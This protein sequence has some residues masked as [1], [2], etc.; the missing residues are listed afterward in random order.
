MS[1]RQGDVAP[2][3]QVATGS[4]LWRSQGRLHLTVIVK[5]TYGL[6][7]GGTMRRA[8]PSPLNED[9]VHYDRR[10][11]QSVRLPSDDVPYLP[12]TDVLFSG[13]VFSPAKLPIPFTKVRLAVQGDGS[14]VEKT[15]HVHGDRQHGPA[16]P[17]EPEPFTE[18]PLVYERAARDPE[19]SENPVGVD[20]SRSGSLPNIVH[21]SDPDRVAGLGPISRYWRARRDRISQRSRE[22]LG[23][24]VMEIASDFDWSYFQAAP[25][26]QQCPH[27]AGDEWVVVEGLDPKICA[28]PS[29]LPGG[30]AVASVWPANR[31]SSLSYPVQMAADA[32]FIDG[33]ARTC[34]VTWRGSF[35][36]ARQAVLEAIYIAAGVHYA[37]EPIDWPAAKAAVARSRPRPNCTAIVAVDLLGT[38][39]AVEHE[40]RA[41]EPAPDGPDSTS[42]LLSS[43]D[44]I[45]VVEPSPSTA[46]SLDP[47]DLQEVIESPGTDQQRAE[48]ADADDLLSTV[49]CDP[50]ASSWP[51]APAGAAESEADDPLNKTTVA[52][53]DADDLL[54]HTVAIDP[55]DD[56]PCDPVAA[57]AEPVA[58]PVGLGA[59]IGIAE[60]APIPALGG[61]LDL[62]GG[63]PASVGAPFSLA[64]APGDP[65]VLRPAVIPGAP[66]CDE[67]AQPVQPPSGDP[68]AETY[69][70]DPAL[71]AAAKATPAGAGTSAWPAAGAAADQGIQPASALRS[72]LLERLTLGQSVA[73]LD[74]S[75]ADLSGLDLAACGLAGAS[76]SGANLRGA[77][78]VK[79]DLSGADLSAADLTHACLDGAK[80]DDANLHGCVLRKASLKGVTLHRADLAEVDGSAANLEKAA[81][82]EVNFAQGNWMG[83]RFFDAQID[84]ADFSKSV[85]DRAVFDSAALRQARLDDVR[86]M[87]LTAIG[88]NLFEV[89]ARRAVL[90][91]CDFTKVVAEGSRWQDALLDD[92]SFN[93]A[94]LQRATFAEASCR[95]IDMSGAGLR[96]IVFVGARLD[97]A[98][99][100]HA[101][102]SRSSLVGLDLSTVDLTG[103]DQDD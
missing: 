87:D 79:A 60:P 24:P 82:Y 99:F 100:R 5:A 19:G 89:N 65:V 48:A 70:L 77:Y 74:L 38:L 41:I 37:N 47:A 11:T 34:T 54:G 6:K 63:P 95:R 75:G 40:E 83:T 102:L 4:L 7:P 103:A 81:G 71:A 51:P 43:D 9:D 59:T 78:L 94:A 72:Q 68:L 15:L 58:E 84:Q 16:G 28:V 86:A 26:D 85:L 90:M 56:H 20:S 93:E 52:A 13:S 32:L 25:L 39:T 42:I 76:L 23:R 45:E 49:H 18:L 35:P 29:R 64:Q 88:A 69:R 1:L 14:L 2:I 46:V 17:T 91:H 67:P 61:T 8:P 53:S 21:P 92:S 12:K 36:I 101:R 10:P 30:T 27:L 66:W 62:L 73:D 80:L 55:G 96:E 50:T 33:H 57:V 97:H 98:S 44:L 3:G 31:Q 22:Q